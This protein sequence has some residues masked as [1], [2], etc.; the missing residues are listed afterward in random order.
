MLSNESQFL[1]KLQVRWRC[2]D[3]KRTIIRVTNLRL[4][5]MPV[6]ERHSSSGL[7]MAYS[8][9]LCTNFSKSDVIS[10]SAL[11]ALVS[12]S[13]SILFK[14]YSIWTVLA[15]TTWKEGSEHS[16]DAGQ[17]RVWGT[18]NVRWT[19][20]DQKWYEKYPRRCYPWWSMALSGAQYALLYRF[21][22][23]CLAKV[24]GL[25]EEGSMYPSLWRMMQ[26]TEF[27]SCYANSQ[28]AERSGLLWVRCCRE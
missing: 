10:L 16:W 20:A 17:G 6:I 11:L 7:F 18:L 23:I 13:M 14:V 21:Q 8:T 24:A 5:R 22:S 12:G 28:S 26:S 15:T 3:F 19:A 27:C 25:D 4:F 1:T 9:L 2:L